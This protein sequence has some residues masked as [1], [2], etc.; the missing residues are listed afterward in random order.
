MNCAYCERP[1]RFDLFSD[2]PRCERH[3]RY[4]CAL[5]LT[6]RHFAALSRC[7]Q[8]NDLFC[9]A[10]AL[11]DEVVGTP[12][13]YTWR[14]TCPF[15]GERHLALEEVEDPRR[16]ADTEA[17][18]ARSLEPGVGFFPPG[19]TPGDAV[20]AEQW[21]RNAQAWIGS[22]G[23][24]GDAARMVSD[25]VLLELLG[26]VRGLC[27]LDAGA[28]EGYLTRI[29]ARQEPARLVA[30]ELSPALVERARSLQPEGVEVLEG[31]VCGM[32]MLAAASFDRLVA[33]N[34]LMYCPDAGAAVREFHRVLRPGGWA[35]VSFSH[36][37]FAGPVSTPLLNPPDSPRPEDGRHRVV[38]NY[39]ARQPACFV[40]PGYASSITFFQ[41]TLGDYFALFRA[42]G[43]GVSH[44]VEP[45]PADPGRL[46]PG[47]FERFSS[48]PLSILFR[49]QKSPGS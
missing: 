30:L 48:L 17:A 5:C 15:C 21:S 34:V 36:P 29:L 37:C 33:N 39:F 9:Q 32:D 28:G 49:L 35:V 7:P 12:S 6:V 16:L 14:R 11:H 44:L 23:P 31:S 43:F 24:S 26:P 13:G 47:F 10:C 38:G 25:P 19:Q 20:V 4:A 46:P 1:A 40:Q 42:A 27:V 45:Q 41:R 3:W 2:R 22:L 8:E 18:V